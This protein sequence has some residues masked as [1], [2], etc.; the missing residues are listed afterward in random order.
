METLANSSETFHLQRL[1]RMSGESQAAVCVCWD[2]NKTIRGIIARIINNTGIL[3]VT[4]CSDLCPT[5]QYFWPGSHSG[6][7]Q[8]LLMV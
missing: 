2:L 3:A 1:R 7:I 6:S 8:I 4:H 5:G